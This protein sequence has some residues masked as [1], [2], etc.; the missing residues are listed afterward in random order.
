MITAKSW[1]VYSLFLPALLLACV[2]NSAS[3][4]TPDS[5][6]LPADRF[7][8]A[9]MLPRAG[10]LLLGGYFT[11]IASQPRSFLAKVN[12]DGSLGSRFAEEPNDTVFCLAQLP[13]GSFLCGG[14]FTKVGNHTI[15]YLAR[16]GADGTLDTG[17]QSGADDNVWALA[18]QPNGQVLVAGGFGHLG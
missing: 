2:L 10:G 6:N 1:R 12:A 17:F 11:N 13:D 5:L 7:V 14:R 15:K 16:T 3:G 9:V 4:Q 18:A 8:Q